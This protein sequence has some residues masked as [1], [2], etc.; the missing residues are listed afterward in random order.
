MY[1]YTYV[2][3]Y[4]LNDPN[5]TNPNLHFRIVLKFKLGLEK[6]NARILL[7]TVYLFKIEARH[8]EQLTIYLQKGEK[9]CANSLNFATDEDIKSFLKHFFHREKDENFVKH[10]VHRK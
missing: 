8:R 1:I 3:T 6:E 9:R 10:K 4:I 7:V 2:C 5:L